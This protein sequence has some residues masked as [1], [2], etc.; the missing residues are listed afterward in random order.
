MKPKSPEEQLIRARELYYSDW[1]AAIAMYRSLVKTLPIGEFWAAAHIDLAMHEYGTANF[2]SAV[3]L[4]QAVL[5]AGNLVEPAGHAI[6]GILQCVTFEMLEADIDEAAVA[7]WVDVAMAT[8]HARDAASGTSLL[9]RC[10]LRRNERERARI[11]M[12]RAVPLWEQ[13]GSMTGGPGILRR[14]ALLDIEEGNVAEA[15]RHFERALE[16]L[17]QFPLGGMAPRFLEKKILAELHALA[18]K[19]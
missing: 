15:R 2:E 1:D 7:S 16:W 14:L 12:E 19:S 10:A 4:T 18:P 13:A 17:R 6:A 5:D 9:A 8:K 11:L 3:R